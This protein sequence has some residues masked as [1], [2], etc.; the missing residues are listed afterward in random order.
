MQPETVVFDPPIPS[1][2]SHTTHIIDEKLWM[3]GGVN[4]KQSSP[5]LMID[6]KTW[7]WREFSLESDD[8]STPLMLHNH[9]STV[10]NERDILIFGGGGNCFSFGT[11][12]NKGII[13]IQLPPEDS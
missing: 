12:F 3:V 9:T 1:R 7:K 11:H 8:P 13:S 2:Y 5:L 6:L 4:L 10:I